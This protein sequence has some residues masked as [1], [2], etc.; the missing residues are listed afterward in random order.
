MNCGTT[1]C[2]TTWRPPRSGSRAKRVRSRMLPLAL[3]TRAGIHVFAGE[4]DAAATLI[5][6][7]DTIAVAT[8]YAPVRYH[9]I[10][11][12]R[13]ARCGGRVRCG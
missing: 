13:L 1:S 7:A 12:S 4:F 8:G 5:E 9:A 2:G 6:E 10:S 11:L 3:A